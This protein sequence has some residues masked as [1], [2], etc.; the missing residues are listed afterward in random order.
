M[1][2]NCII[3]ENYMESRESALVKAELN[4]I[5]NGYD[6][7]IEIIDGDYRVVTDT[8]LTDDKKTCI[9]EMVLKAIS[10]ETTSFYN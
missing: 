7:R 10:G 8:Y 3:S 6:G 2:K 9:S 1:L 5:A 4:R